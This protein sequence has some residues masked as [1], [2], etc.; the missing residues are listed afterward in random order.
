[1]FGKQGSGTYVE[2][3]WEEQKGVGEM[4]AVQVDVVVEGLAK[5]GFGAALMPDDVLAE[6]AGGV[7]EDVDEEDPEGEGLDEEEPEL[8]VLVE[9]VLVLA[10]EELA[11]EE[12]GLELELVLIVEET[13]ELVEETVELVEENV[14]LVEE[15]EL[16]VMVDL[17][18]TLQ[19]P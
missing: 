1:M 15:D 7:V 16:V 2:D 5:A 9:D 12:L 11:E 6:A 14:E 17:A 19:V 8:V 13:V 18:G 10:E 3:R 4:V